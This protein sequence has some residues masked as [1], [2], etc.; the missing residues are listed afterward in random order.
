MET[1]PTGLSGLNVRIHVAVEISSVL[2]LAQTQFHQTVVLL[3]KEI[4]LSSKVVKMPSNAQVCQKSLEIHFFMYSSI[5]TSN[6]ATF[7]IE[8]INFKLL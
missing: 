6:K 2:V 5:N 7:K 8:F 1:I 4:E 3:V